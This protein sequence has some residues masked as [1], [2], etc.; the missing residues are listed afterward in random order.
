MNLIIVQMITGALGT[1]SEMFPEN[2]KVLKI[3]RRIKTAALLNCYI[4]THLH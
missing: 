4:A 2:L 1:F 3:Q